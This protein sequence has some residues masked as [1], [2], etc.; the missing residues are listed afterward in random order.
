MTGR[1]ALLAAFD[2]LYDAALTKLDAT[3]TEEE[4][5]AAR[6]QFE[7]RFSQALE[8]TS[9]VSMAGG[10]PAEALDEMKGAIASLSKAELAALVATV[11]LA[12]RAQ[13]MVRS[14]AMHT[15]QQKLLEHLASQA[16][17]RWGN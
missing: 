10:V 16:D 17:T 4:R 1:E 5:T 13:D 2:E 9:T 14:I 11:P 15:A 12:Q 7:R 6:G 3:A 8:M